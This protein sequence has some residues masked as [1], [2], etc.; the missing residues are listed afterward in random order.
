MEALGARPQ[1][2]V[3]LLGMSVYWGKIVPEDLLNRQSSDQEQVKR[4]NQ[5]R[6]G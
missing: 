5:G 6:S 4:E 3:Y 1:V 2:C